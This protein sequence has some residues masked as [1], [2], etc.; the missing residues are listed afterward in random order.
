[1]FEHLI[2][3]YELGG[4]TRTHSAESLN[5]KLAYLFSKHLA[6]IGEPV[7]CEKKSALKRL[8]NLAV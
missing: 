6:Q 5:G 2:I 3:T 7:K 8:F 1:M 4:H